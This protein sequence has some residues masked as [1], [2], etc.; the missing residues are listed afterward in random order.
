ML[1]DIRKE[2][3]WAV[4]RLYSTNAEGETFT[5]IYAVVKRLEGLLRVIDEEITGFDEEAEELL[6]EDIEEH[7]E[8]EEYLLEAIRQAATPPDS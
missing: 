5:A 8:G 4:G 7:V 1:E 6:M 2:I 3:Q